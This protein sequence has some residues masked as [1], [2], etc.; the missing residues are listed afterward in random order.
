MAESLPFVAPAD[1]DVVG[2][3]AEAAAVAA[4]RAGVA[5]A[6]L[7]GPAAMEQ[8]AA[9]V[10]AVWKSPGSAGQV[11][12]SLLRA[13]QH[14]GNF[15]AGAYLGTELMGVS[16]GFFTAGDGRTMHSH[17][18]C[19]APRWQGRGLGFALKLYQ[20]AWAL[21]RGVERVTWTFD[22]LVRR[23]AYFNLAK[24]AGEVAEYLPDFYGRM[25]D[26]VNAGDR[27]DRLQLSWPL[28]DEQ[29]VAASEGRPRLAGFE[30]DG[31]NVLLEEDGDGAPRRLEAS[32]EWL[33]CRVPGDVVLVRASD[34]GL[35]LRWRL[36]VRE[37]LQDA[38]RAGYRVSGFTRSG[39]YLLSGAGRSGGSGAA[40]G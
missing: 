39:Y 20:R 12:P 3:A 24:L 5:T 25:T 17:L 36:A 35:A 7:R 30:P 14:T 8:A 27:S 26:G 34:P 13:L 28:A 38:L 40:G 19:A 31:A 16:V 33:G 32:G 6:E 22:P 29:V 18:T 1:T 15:V 37:T 11:D 10:A 21:E 23:N 9:L 4:D 2:R